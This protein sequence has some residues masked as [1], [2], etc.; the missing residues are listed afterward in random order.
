[1]RTLDVLHLATCDLHTGDSLAT[2]DV[3]LRAA[4]EQFAITLVPARSEDVIFA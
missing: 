1:M 3:R 2:T 4:C